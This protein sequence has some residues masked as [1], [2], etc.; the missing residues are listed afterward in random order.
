M[1]SPFTKRVQ[2][3]RIH[4]RITEME[5]WALNSIKRFRL[6]SQHVTK[7]CFVL[8]INEDD[9]EEDGATQMI[10][11]SKCSLTRAIVN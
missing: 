8:G 3:P 6:L 4:L 2:N 10:S 11:L 1:N 5:S 7:H 9:D